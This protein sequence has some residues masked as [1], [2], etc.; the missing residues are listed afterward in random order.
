MLLEVQNGWKVSQARKDPGVMET[1]M[2]HVVLLDAVVES[3]LLD[4]FN[5][6]QRTK[7]MMVSGGMEGE[8][9][10]E[11]E[12]P[13]REGRRGEREREEREKKG[14]GRGRGKR[15]KEGKR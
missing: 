5:N 15:E 2:C 12:G 11:G 7:S 14:E 4:R 13:L 3:G 1:A 10:R 8:G 6:T 9:G